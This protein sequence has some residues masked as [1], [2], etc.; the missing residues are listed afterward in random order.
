MLVEKIQ[1]YFPNHHFTTDR[2]DIAFNN[3]F[4]YYVDEVILPDGIEHILNNAHNDSIVIVRNMYLSKRK[5]QNWQQLKTIKDVTV[6]VDLFFM[7]LLF[8]RKEQG[9]QEFKLRLF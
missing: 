5:T 4:I 3:P 6:S 7:G 9:K 8:V 2:K 1:L